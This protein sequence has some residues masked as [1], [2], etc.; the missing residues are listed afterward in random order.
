MAGISELPK[1]HGWITPEYAEEMVW[2][3]LD[4]LK[5]YSK[6]GSIYDLAMRGIAERKNY[7]WYKS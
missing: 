3:L 6:N 7:S 2:N 4:Y 1:L 5:K